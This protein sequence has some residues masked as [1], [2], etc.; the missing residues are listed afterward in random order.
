MLKKN[1]TCNYEESVVIRSENTDVTFE[2]LTALLNLITANDKNARLVS[3]CAGELICLLAEK[4]IDLG[5]VMNF[6]Q[7]SFN[8]QNLVVQTNTGNV[9]Q[10]LCSV[11]YK[12]LIPHE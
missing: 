11:R 12:Y 8:Q 3:D 9:L 2:I 5:P 4:E 1:I 6:I 7:N 10:H